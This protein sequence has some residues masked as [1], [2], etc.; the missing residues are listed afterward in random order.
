M[1]SK[2]VQKSK[3]N[4]DKEILKENNINIESKKKP[5][6]QIETFLNNENSNIEIIITFSE[7]ERA[8]KMMEFQKAKENKEN[9]SRDDIFKKSRRK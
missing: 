5:R 9:L 4:Q 2:K 7:I 8:E 1:I 6:K 3:T